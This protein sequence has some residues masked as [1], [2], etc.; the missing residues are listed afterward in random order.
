[1]QAP[2]RARSSWR[3]AFARFRRDRWSFVAACVFAV[4]LVVSL[5]GG[6][7]A[8]ALLGHNGTDIFPY[9]ANYSLK[10]VGPWTRVPATHNSYGYANGG[11]AAPPKGAPTTLLIF[12]ADGPLGRDEFIRV[13]DGGKAS[14]EIALGGVLVALLIGLPLGCVSG[15]F[16]GLADTFV[17][18]VTDTVMAF[19]LLLFLVFASVNLDASLKPIGAWGSIIPEGV[20][21]E[22]VLIGVFTSF[23]PTRLV[24][25]RLLTLRQ[26]EFVEAAEMVG[27]SHWRILRYHL[28]PYLRPMLIVWAAIA[29]ATNILLE[30]GL[31]FVGAGVQPETPT[32]GSLLS[33]TWGT[34]YQPQ[35]FDKTQFTVWQTVFPTVAILLCVVSLNQLS[36]GLRHA[37]EPEGGR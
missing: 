35:V 14:L 10:P 20:V 30:V 37:L 13:V 5:A 16:G 28:L 27:A 18:R 22:A 23:Y 34:I 36:E 7:T 9:A 29:T 17:T 24:R 2:P 8:S 33:T 12:G 25:A 21:A 3:L 31:S 19:P 32:W 15:Y 11:L 4:I 6:A 1:M 26:E